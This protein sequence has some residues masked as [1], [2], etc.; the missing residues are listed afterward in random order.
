[1]TTIDF[2]QRHKTEHWKS[3]LRI[4]NELS[5]NLMQIYRRV[6]RHVFRFNRAGVGQ[7]STPIGTQHS[8]NRW[9]Q[10]FEPFFCTKPTGSGLGLSVVDRVA[11][12]H[13][14]DIVCRSVS[15][16]GTVFTLTL[17]NREPPGLGRSASV[18]ESKYGSL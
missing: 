3:V 6:Q 13:G 14:G 17:A 4:F 15:G 5:E 16:L 12:A 10:I 7:R 1:M 11:R 8:A 18:W 2:R 9:R